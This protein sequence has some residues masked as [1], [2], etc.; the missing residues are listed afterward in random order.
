VAGSLKEIEEKAKSRFQSDNQKT[1][2]IKFKAKNPA[3]DEERD[4]V[5]LKT[6]KNTEI[7]PQLSNR[8]NKEKDIVIEFKEKIVFN[9]SSNTKNSEEPK[10]ALELN[11]K[12]SLA[13]KD[14]YDE[15]MP[16]DARASRSEGKPAKVGISL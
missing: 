10:R 15:D 3:K 9:T 7:D 14:R 1:K 6:I 11:K 2:E 12:K 8:K 5:H 16:D 4:S 13:Q